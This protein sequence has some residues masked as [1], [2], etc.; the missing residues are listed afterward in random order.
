[1]STSIGLR[2]DNDVVDGDV[3][4]LDEEPDEAHQGKP[5]GC[6]Y[7]D[8]L[9]L[10]PVGLGAFFDKAVRVLGKLLGRVDHLHNLIHF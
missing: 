5:N 9:E 4:E 10:F 3:D 8:L 7:G 2:S 1:M 6:C